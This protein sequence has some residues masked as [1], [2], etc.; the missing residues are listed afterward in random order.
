MTAAVIAFGAV[1]ALGED[2]RAI[3]AGEPGA[4]ARVAIAR[5]NTFV[6][7]GFARPHVARAR[8]AN[9]EG[10][11]EFDRVKPLV[12]HAVRTCAHSLDEVLPEWRGLRIG[13]ALA[14]SSGGMMSAEKFFAEAAGAG[15][16]VERLR[17]LACDA[18]YFSPFLLAAGELAIPTFAP[19]TLILTACAAS[20]IAMGVGARWLEAGRCD[21]VLAGG[22]DAV[23]EFVGSGFEVLRATTATIP[24]RPF[25]KTRD[26]MSL[27][28]G[29][30]IVAMV[31]ASRAKR[32][33]AFV[34]GFGAA[35]DAV[36]LTAPDR[37]GGGLLR[38]GRAALADAGLDGRVID[39]VSGHATATPYNDAA[40]SA[41]IAGLAEGGRPVMHAFKAQLGHTL[42]AAGVLESLALIDALRRGIL[43]ATPVTDDLEA[44]LP[45]RLLAVSE[46]RQVHHALKLSA[47]F[48]GANASL[49]L[50]KA[51]PPPG[52][53][54]NRQSR[55]VYVGRAVHLT[56]APG[57][58]ELALRLGLA[59]DKLSRTDPLVRM[60]LA[61]CDAL[62]SEEA[63]SGASL[64]GAG[65]VV[66][67]ALA[68]F[69]TNATYAA[70]LRERGIRGVEPRKFPY[71]SPNAVAGECGTAFGW[72][73]PG[74]AL[75]AGLHAAVEALAVAIDLVRAGDADRLVVLAV[76]EIG[77]AARAWQR[78]ALGDDSWLASGAAALVVSSV[79]N[80]ARSARVLRS[81]SGFDAKA[82]THIGTDKMSEHA[83]ALGHRALLPMTAERLVTRLRARCP[84]G[85]FAE[86][87]LEEVG[88]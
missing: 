74:I 55:P 45:I 29:A 26:G 40:E 68:T 85:G 80:G 3:D 86:V 78:A 8:L 32:A 60:A 52:R 38:A 88:N 16:A 42:G 44:D 4:P 69:E 41:A 61:A 30:A 49:V 79:P 33:M 10:A 28:E 37:T 23:S 20:T 15:P 34:S 64:D 48:G 2:D 77:D 72:R 67:H 17:S 58:E 35:A 27:G 13:L 31:D 65:I 75:G 5:D 59:S 11:E 9:R 71:T 51:E 54:P 56:E 57:L 25:T 53:R 63:A 12:E 43:P 14:T 36:H 46:A 22:F 66:G 21:L 1:S 84:F 18:A 83:G 47:A 62:R 81:V 7:R 70:R 6:E 19:A 39:V 87:E 24:P 76:D 82:S 50:S 73:G